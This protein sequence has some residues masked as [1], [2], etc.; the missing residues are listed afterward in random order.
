MPL[1]LLV[2][3]SLAGTPGVGAVHVVGPDYGAEVAL[4][5]RPV[6]RLPLDPIPVA[7]GLHLVELLRGGRTVWSRVVYV[8]PDRTVRLTVELAPAAGPS[9]TLGDLKRATPAPRGPPTRYLLT[10]R[11]AAEAAAAG[12]A[13]DLDLAQRWRL[14]AR[15]GRTISAAVEVRAVGDVAGEGVELSRVVHRGTDDPLLVEALW[16][17]AET[18]VVDARL[19]RMPQSGPMDRAFLLDGV[20]LDGD[21]GPL[22]WHARGGRRFA[23]LGTQPDSPWLGGAGLSWAVGGW[24]AA[25]HGTY[26][27]GLSSDA[28]L[29][30]ERGPLRAVARGGLLDADPLHADVRASLDLSAATAGWLERLALGARW[31][32]DRRS[33][34]DM[35]VALT[36]I[37]A[38]DT[39]AG[40][41]FDGRLTTRLGPVQTEL[42]AGLFEGDGP[43][44]V[45]RPARRWVT[46]DAAWPVGVWRLLAGAG[47]L[48]ADPGPAP[49]AVA[50]AAR[51][52]LTGGAELR[53][54]RLRLSGE[55]GL[56]SLT[57]VGGEVAARVL[58]MGGVRASLGLSE[59]VVL[60][61]AL[62]VA[63]AHPT[64]DPHGGPWVS[65]RLGIEIR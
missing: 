57:L 62:D 34:F 48:D 31:R 44:R 16:L 41:T 23:A 56:E 64:L 35:P 14:D 45:E 49:T 8:A 53:R 1:M 55:I 63:A 27:D 22:S 26:H 7:P 13:W 4:D 42:R 30:F 51:R 12:D 3:A 47:A 37:L 17:R 28:R 59:A 58:P 61:G 52:H 60:F 43:A 33:P 5:R 18:D 36:T 65:G 9:P 39:P 19:G 20:R 24:S 6:G 15:A 40:A 38:L 2:L 10:G 21:A 29:A 50:L 54:G 46:L 25:L 32:G 11:I